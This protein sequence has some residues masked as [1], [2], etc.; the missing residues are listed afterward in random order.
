MDSF[1]TL[2]SQLQ[3]VCE[4]PV[5][6]DI[7]KTVR[8]IQTRWRQLTA[9][10]STRCRLFEQSLSRWDKYEN[11]YS[12]ILDWLDGK[13]QYCSE[14]ITMRDDPNQRKESL[15]KSRVRRVECKKNLWLLLYFLLA[16]CILLFICF[17]SFLVLFSVLLCYLLFPF[18]F[19]ILIW[20]IC[21]FLFILFFL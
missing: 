13:E 15:A 3:Q 9:D 17:C 2:A 7:K 10:L 8:D 21:V 4:A 11:L 16:F 1:V 20:S 6:A 14:L 18:Y 12:K 19:V 5:Q